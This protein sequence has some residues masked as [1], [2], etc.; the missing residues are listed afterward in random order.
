M[1]EDEDGTL[2][3]LP[4]HRGSMDAAIAR[5]GGRIVGEAGDSVLAE[6]PAAV[7]AVC[8]AIE[9]Q[10]ELHTLNAEQP[11]DRRMEFRIGINMGDV[12]V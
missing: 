12:I 8:C 11:P 3:T 2:S 1:G 10:E 5:H 6:F 7:A 9:I 4:A